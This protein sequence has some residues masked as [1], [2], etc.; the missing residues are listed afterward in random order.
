MTVQRADAP[1][2]GRRRVRRQRILVVSGG[3]TED[4]YL[5]GFARSIGN[6]SVELTLKVG[7]AGALQM[8]E[9]A[10]RLIDHQNDDFDE[11]WCVADVDD[12]DIVAAGKRATELG[13]HLLVSNPCFELWLLLHFERC[14]TRLNRCRDAERL[15]R[16]HLPAYRKAALRFRDFEAGLAEACDRAKQSENAAA[17]YPNP[18]TGM[19]RLVERMGGG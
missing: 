8:I 6:R 5:R 3:P 11:I 9:H 12:Y 15:L 2:R 1:T 13:V 19:W 4:G 18:S 7:P 17:S 16:R 10:R 14:T